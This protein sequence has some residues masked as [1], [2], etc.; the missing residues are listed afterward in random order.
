MDEVLDPRVVG[1]ALRRNPVPPANVGVVSRPVRVVEGWIGDDEVSL[2]VLVKIALERVS[3][4]R[5]EVSLDT[6]DGEVH[7][8]QSACGVVRFL[9]VDRDVADLATV[10]LHELL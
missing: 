1:V 4:L 7:H 6:P 8:R 3:V 2:Q 9:A 10:A 5:A